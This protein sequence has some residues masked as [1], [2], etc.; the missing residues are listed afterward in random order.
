MGTDNAVLTIPLRRFGQRPDEPSHY[1]VGTRV[2]AKRSSSGRY[3][4]DTPDGNT[5]NLEPGELHL[6]GAPAEPA[7]EYRSGFYRTRGRI[8]GTTHLPDLPPGALIGLI[9]GGGLTIWAVLRPDGWVVLLD[10]DALDRAGAERVE[11]P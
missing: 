9:P 4:V 6:D 8:D 10:E 5:H 2:H 11:A 7:A 3:F 1:P